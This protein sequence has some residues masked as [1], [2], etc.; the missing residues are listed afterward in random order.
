MASQDH[1]ELSQ[2]ETSIFYFVYMYFWT[3]QNIYQEKH[4][5]ILNFQVP[6]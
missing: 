2:L 1:N 5:F 3:S 4:A 6:I